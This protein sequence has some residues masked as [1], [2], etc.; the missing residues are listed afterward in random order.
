[1]PGLT[2]T[3]EVLEV[4]GAV[5]PDCGEERLFPLPGVGAQCRACLKRHPDLEF[6]IKEVC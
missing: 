6:L 4:G 1:M 3:V 2:P 5:C